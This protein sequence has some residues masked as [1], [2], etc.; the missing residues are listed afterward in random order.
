MEVLSTYVDWICRISLPKDD[1]RL[2]IKTM[3]HMIMMAGCSIFHLSLIFS[4]SGKYFQQQCD[5]K[6]DSIFQYGSA[7]INGDN[8]YIIYKVVLFSSA[9]MPRSI[10]YLMTSSDRLVQTSAKN[11]PAGNRVIAGWAVES[12]FCKYVFIYLFCVLCM[13]RSLRLG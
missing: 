5:K 7:Q 4:I 6:I 9:Q 2:L 1:Y 12:H 10:F 11:S 8:A 13:F 3:L